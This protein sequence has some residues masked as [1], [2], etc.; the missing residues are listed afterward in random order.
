LAQVVKVSKVTPQLGRVQIELEAGVTTSWNAPIRAFRV[1]RSFR[2]FGD[3][4][5]P[6]FTNPVTDSSGKITG[7]SSNA[8]RFERYIYYSDS[9]WGF[10]AGYTS[11]NFTEMPL[12]IEAPDLASGSELIVRG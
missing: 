1:G 7:S 10:G 4:A 11:L 9:T 2:H 12:D 3:S 5:P 8:T 6:S